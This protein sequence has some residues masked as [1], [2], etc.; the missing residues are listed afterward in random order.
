MGINLKSLS[1]Y[2]NDSM[3]NSYHYKK[4]ENYKSSFSELSNLLNLI[5]NN[6]E[7]K[8]DALTESYKNLVESGTVD[9]L[10]RSLYTNIDNLKLKLGSFINYIQEHQKP[11]NIALVF[12]KDALNLHEKFNRSVDSKKMELALRNNNGTINI[13]SKSYNPEYLK[14][15]LDR[16]SIIEDILFQNVTSRSGDGKLS[17]D[18]AQ[19]IINDVCKAFSI[20]TS[21]ENISPK[22]LHYMF[23]DNIVSDSLNNDTISEKCSIRNYYDAFSSMRCNIET[24]ASIDDN[25]TMVLLKKIISFNYS[26][27]ATNVSTIYQKNFI[28]TDGSII[29]DNY[30]INYCVDTIGTITDIYF[31]YS[32]TARQTLINAIENSNKIIR[33]CED[34]YKNTYPQDFNT[35]DNATESFS[36]DLEECSCYLEIY[37]ELMNEAMYQYNLD[38]YLSEAKHSN[39]SPQGRQPNHVP[40]QNNGSNNQQQQNQNS[41]NQPNNNQQNNQNN[42]N[43]QNNQSNNDKQNSGENQ[44]NQQQQ[45]QNNNTQQ[46]NQNNN[47]KKKENDDGIL[48]RIID[49]I[50]KIIDKIK[51]LFDRFM[52]RTR[53]IATAN[54]NTKFWNSYRERIR[55]LDLSNV[56]VSDWYD[57]DYDTIVNK[58]VFVEFDILK[59]ELKSN[60]DFGNYIIRQVTGNNNI[61]YSDGDFSNVCKDM[62]VTKYFDS[63]NKVKYSG[64]ETSKHT[65]DLIVLLDDYFARGGDENTTIN[66]SISDDIKKLTAITDKLSNKE[67]MNQLVEKLEKSNIDESVSNFDIYSYTYTSYLTETSRLSRSDL[68]S[69]EFGVKELRKFPLDTKKHVLSAVKFFNHVDPA[70]ENE[71]AKNILSKIKKFGI[72]LKSLLPKNSNNRFSKYIKIKESTGSIEESFNLA[73]ELGLNT[74][75]EI[76]IDTHGASFDTGDNEDSVQAEYKKLYGVLQARINRYLTFMTKALGARE[77]QALAMIKQ[78]IELYRMVFN[79]KSNDDED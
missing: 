63:N 46:N 6:N 54:A 69:S 15:I 34:I 22:K 71:L 16:K 31:M 24:L 75:H 13:L 32:E 77:T 50:R 42:N 36:K 76:E 27:I 9:A 65:N 62:Y 8:Y 25:E 30:V 72:D 48:E 60:E 14:A 47:K 64:T 21:S 19:N 11:N 68:S 12:Y 38:T 44:S 29:T 10:N 26:N 5:N 18:W 78:T 20:N 58:S 61:T 17:A 59:P 40:N 1:S 67:F 73:K 4:I 56:E 35:T 79:V 53:E 2:D 55:T 3:D 52:G 41:N 7:N 23:L 28:G 74:L 45:N 51:A 37:R 43:Q 49:L 39:R 66:K 57:Y 70:H 33:Y